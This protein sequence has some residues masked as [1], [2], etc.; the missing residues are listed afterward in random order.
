MRELQDPDVG[1]I[2]TALNALADASATRSGAAAGGPTLH[3][4]SIDGAHGGLRDAADVHLLDYFRVLHKRRWTAGWVVIAAL[5][6]VVIYVTT[7]TPIYEASTRL[8]IEAEKQNV[9]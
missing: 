1:Q 8:L 9:V 6:G 3:G 7:A 2:Q 4:G 5:L